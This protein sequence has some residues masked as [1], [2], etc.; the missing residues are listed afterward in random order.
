M[1]HGGDTRLEKMVVTVFDDEKKAYEGS[2][3]LKE[4]DADGSIS[5]HA[6]AV[7][8]RNPDGTLDTKEISGDFPVRTVEGTAVGALIGLLGGPIGLGVGAATGA[9]AGFIGDMHRAGVN[10]DYY[11]DVTADLTPGKWAVVSDISEEWETPID[12]EME[13]LGGNVF[14]T[15]RITVLKEQDKRA[16]AAIKNEI[17]HLKKEQALRGQKEKAKIQAKIDSLNAKLKEESEKVKKRSLQENREME[18]KVHALQEKAKK[19]TGDTKSKI[20]ARIASLR[21]KHK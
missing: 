21:E 14:R 2:R 7:V 4:L 16:D 19:A 5:V 9:L 15:P 8:K 12:S 11:D 13:R 18:A 6:E 1:I 3:A 10:A 17:A 20:Q